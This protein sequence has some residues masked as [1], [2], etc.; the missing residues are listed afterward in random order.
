MYIHKPHTMGIIDTMTIQ[1]HLFL[2][3]Y[4]AIKTYNNNNNNNNLH[5]YSTFHHV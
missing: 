4:A 3:T 2:A 5:L 1:F